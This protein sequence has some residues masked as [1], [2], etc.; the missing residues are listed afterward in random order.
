[1]N[2]DSHRFLSLPDAVIFDVDGTLCDVRTVRHHVERPEGAI[3]F[4]PNF[5][6]FHSESISCPA[7]PQVVNLLARARAAGFA[8]IVV[9][10]REEKWSFITS[11]WLSEHDV[12]YDELLMRPSRDSRHDAVV[13]S[14]IERYIARRYNARLAI[15][16]R[17][18]I[19][20]V[21]QNAGIATS[22]VSVEGQLGPIKWP[23]EAHRK[24]FGW[25]AP[26]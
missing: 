16:D 12:L 9:T 13:K 26:S 6:L 11:T 4:T 19:L 8:V 3:R 1:M 24:E 22:R 18:D 2:L 15:D 25:F 7:H 23:S 20:E 14:E 21:W 17:A 5:N 10:G